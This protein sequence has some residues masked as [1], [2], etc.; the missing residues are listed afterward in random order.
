[1]VIVHLF[2]NDT[3]PPKAVNDCIKQFFCNKLHFNTR[4]FPT[5][6]GKG[7]LHKSL[8]IKVCKGFCPFSRL[9]HKAHIFHSVNAEGAPLLIDIVKCQKIV[10][11]RINDKIKWADNILGAALGGLIQISDF[12]GEI[13][14][15]DFLRLVGATIQHSCH[16]VID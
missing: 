4:S 1:M 8:Y 6:H 10:V 2:I 3:A 15:A 5:V 14:E 16:S 11:A 9:V 12:I 7:A 13:L